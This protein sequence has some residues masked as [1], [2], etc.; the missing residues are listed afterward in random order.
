MPRPR[1]VPIPPVLA[2]QPAM[3]TVRAFPKA[4]RHL[5]QVTL[6]SEAGLAGSCCCWGAAG[7][8]LR[9]RLPPPLGRPR[10]RRCR[11]VGGEPEERKMGWL[12][13]RMIGRA[14]WQ[15]PEEDL[16]V[17]LR[18]M[19]PWVSACLLGPVHK[20]SI[21][22]NLAPSR[23]ANVHAP[24]PSN[25]SPRCDLRETPAHSHRETS[26]GNSR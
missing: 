25:P 20:I 24:Q 23:R 9:R 15:V 3:G 16:E 12:T 7:P 13:T 21:K 17:G 18:A 14:P 1:Q 19:R 2:L 4:H 22:Y 8:P 10:L 26:N 11:L 5:P 6:P